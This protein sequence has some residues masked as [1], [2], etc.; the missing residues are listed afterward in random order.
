[1]RALL[2][3]S[4]V[5]IGCLKIQAQKDSL[6]LDRYFF[7]TYSFRSFNLSEPSSALFRSSSSSQPSLNTYLD[8][9]KP[10]FCRMESL[11]EQRSGQALK[12]RLGSVEVVD[13]YEG[14]DD[15]WSIH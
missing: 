1:M 2:V 15:R 14:K 3:I 11:W 8:G 9:K 12:F 4:F 6:D 10:F 7:N 5:L 13:R